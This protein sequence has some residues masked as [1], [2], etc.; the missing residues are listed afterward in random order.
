MKYKL[1]TPSSS[2][3]NNIVMAFFLVILFWAITSNL[4]IVEILRTEM[5]KQGLGENVI[6][7][8]SKQVMLLWT[9]LTIAG[10]LIAFFI[11]LF[12]SNTI[13]RPLKKLTESMINIASGKWDTRI[14]TDSQDEIGQLSDGFNFMAEQT[15]KAFHD[16]ESAKDYVDSIL[17]SSPST[18]IVLDNR[19]NI[20]STNMGL[21]EK[22]EI[23]PS[24]TPQQFIELLENDI[25]ENL[26]NGKTINNEIFITPKG[27]ETSLAFSAVVSEIG[28]EDETQDNEESPRVLLSLTNI[29]DK[30][31]SEEA[32]RKSQAHLNTIIE[33]LPFDLFALDIDGRYSL[34]NSSM[35]KHAG[36]IIGKRPHDMAPDK[37]TLDKWLVNNARAFKGETVEGEIT[38]KLK[39]EQKYFHNIITPVYE[40]DNIRS[41]LGINIDITE[42]KRVEDALR[43]SEDNY[44]SIFNTANDAIFIHDINDG[45]IIDINRKMLEMYGFTDKKEIIG[46][47]VDKL[48]SGVKPFTVENATEKVKAAINDGPQLFEWHAK[49]KNG[50]LFWVEVNLK[51][52]TVSRKDRILAI[53]RDISNRKKSEIEL[54]KAKEEIEAWNKELEDRVYK[55]TKELKE[56]EAQLIQSAKLSAMGLLAAGLAHE[57]NSPLAGLLPLLGKYKQQ[58]EKDTQAYREMSLM[59]KACEHMTKIIRDFGVF[60]REKKTDFEE[61]ILNNIIESTLTFSAGQLLKNGVE[62]VKEYDNQLP[63]I[64][65][66]ITELQQVILNIITNARDTMPDGGRLTIKTGLLYNSRDVFMEFTDNGTGIAKEHINKIFDPFFTT[67]KQGDGVGL[68][69]SVSYGI[70]KNHKGDISVIS[71]TGKGAQFKISLPCI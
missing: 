55:Q 16:A 19:L 37:E 39:G 23:Y 24:P 64:L 46:S 71:E 66:N 65:G 45:A 5:Q 48:S 25:M 38:F 42:R 26:K 21:D 11:A 56:S 47:F 41:I 61:I 63:A 35:R 3:K 13:T 14:K 52:V 59:L 58:Q 60:S 32:L 30:K 57:L 17:V 10:S 1:K 27:S 12:L 7:H 34:Q 15:Q 49:D 28:I 31:L 54:L 20:L 69:L 70:I 8:I 67:K 4:V 44:R 50:N 43:A 29:T 22:H 9:S 18:L 2:L 51:K 6:Q 40:E 68:G 36:N 33:S 62:I 53:V